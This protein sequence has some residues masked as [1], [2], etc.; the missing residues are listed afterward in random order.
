MKGSEDKA[1]EKNFLNM[2]NHMLLS[3]DAK[4]WISFPQTREKRME[5][6]LFMNRYIL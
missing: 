1:L 5:L 3:K 2:L 4:I 6:M